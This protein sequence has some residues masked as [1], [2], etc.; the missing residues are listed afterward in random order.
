MLTLSELQKAFFIAIHSENPS[1]LSWIKA[2]NKLSAKQ[3]FDILK[4]SIESSL[5]KTLN[6]IYPVCHQLVGGEFFLMLIN[7]YIKKFSSYSFDLSDYGEEFYR[8]IQCYSS[9]QSLPYL[10][11]VAKLE[12]AWHRIAIM[13]DTSDFHFDKLQDSEPGNQVFTLPY[14]SHLLSSSYP[15]H[16]IWKV[17][18]ESYMGD[19]TII[20]ENNK[21]Y[22][23]LVWRKQQEL[24]IDPV[25]ITEWH[26]L[27]LLAKKYSLKEIIT[28]TDSEEL[29]TYL[30]KMIQHGWIKNPDIS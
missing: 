30:P 16:T 4:N 17:N 2:S 14:G 26:I 6:S 9:V 22:Y 23:Y 19:K 11:D 1:D 24:R 10:S 25:N 18:Q 5:Q 7:D 28:F 29:V 27:Q 3:Q 21:T 20:L 13:G 8:F 15:I 12:W